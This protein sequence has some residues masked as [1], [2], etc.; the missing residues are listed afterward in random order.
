MV[1]GSIVL[2]GT[3]RELL[4]DTELASRYLGVDAVIAEGD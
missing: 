3:G 2:S 1:D 4:Q